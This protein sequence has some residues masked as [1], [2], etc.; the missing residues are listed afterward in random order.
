MAVPYLLANAPRI[1]QF[2]QPRR[3]APSGV[4]VVHTAESAPDEKGPD[5]GTDNVARFI[6]DR[7]TYGSYHWLAD[8]D[9]RLQLVPYE[10]EAYGDGTG[11]NPHAVHISAATQAARWASL[12]D[13]WVDGTIQEM[14]EAAADYNRWR[15]AR[16]M[17]AIPARRITRAQ[18]EARVP[19]FISHGERD[20][21]RRSD[22]GAAFPWVAFLAAYARLA[23]ADLPKPPTPKPAP[24]PGRADAVAQRTALTKLAQA[25][26][27][28][29]LL[30][31][32]KAAR[33]RLPKGKP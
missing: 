31:K 18:S 27:P 19:G 33:N 20:P 22:P 29:R 14:A 5:T 4:V 30:N 23:A 28:G 24:R 8:S 17:T 13:D 11:S 16:G 1:R 2:R 26:K 9:S 7:T 6:R 25:L 10:A 32:V 3:A 12:G 15:I 21:G